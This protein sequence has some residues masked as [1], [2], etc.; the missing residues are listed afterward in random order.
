MIIFISPSKTFSNVIDDS[1]LTCLFETKTN[2]LLLKLKAMT[3]EEITQTFKLSDKLSKDVFDYYQNPKYGKAIELYH[4]VQYKALDYKSIRHST[5]TLYIMS[6][7]Y[8]L[9]RP[10]M[11]IQK[12]RLDFFHH[13]FKNLYE[14]WQKDIEDYLSKH[15]LNEMFINLASEEF[16]SLIKNL[17]NVYTIQFTSN[18][19]LS[20]VL[21]KQVRGMLA[22]LLLNSNAKTLADIKAINALGFVYKDIIDKDIIFYLKQ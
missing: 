15:H 7:L 3:I 6:A 17:E 11:Y 2:K 13:P 1:N 4:G 19:R 5:N 18:K 8:G 21:L 9:L 16:G 22:R 20:S 12:Y 14:Y 10:D